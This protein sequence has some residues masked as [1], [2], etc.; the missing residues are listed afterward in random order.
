MALR[1]IYI[2]DEEE[3]TQQPTVTDPSLDEY[4]AFVRQQLKEAAEQTVVQDL[5]KSESYIRETGWTNEDSI[6]AAQR[7]FSSAALGWGDEAVIWTGAL[8]DSDE[9]NSTQELYNKRKKEYDERQRAFAERNPKAAMAADIVGGF[10][11]PALAIKAGTTLGRIGIS[12]AE[13]AIYGAG[14]AEEGER[15]SGLTTGAAFGGG[16]TAAFSLVGKAGSQLYRRRIDGDLVDADGDF[17]PL[18]I[19][20]SNPQ[21][22][23]GT[24]HTFYRDVVAP[25]FGGKG[26]IKAQEEKIIGKVEDLLESKQAFDKKLKVGLKEAEQKSKN[27]MSDALEKTRDE[28]LESKKVVREA[29]GEKGASLKS[30]LSAFQSKKSEEIA[31][32]ALKLTGDALDASNF[33]FRNEAYLRSMPSGATQDDIARVFSKETPGEIAREIDKTWGK[34]GYSMIKEKTFRFKKNELEQAIKERIEKSPFLQVDV[35]SNVPVM[36][37]FSQVVDN[38]KAFKDPNSRITGEKASEIRSQLGSL[39]YRQTDDQV[40]FALYGL[41][42]ELD[43]VIKSQ[44]TSKQLKDFQKESDKWKTTVILRDAIEKSQTTTSR[45]AFDVSDWIKAVSRNNK[46]DNRYGAGPLNQKARELEVDHKA[47]E[48]SIARRAKAVAVQKANNIEKT[49]SDHNKELTAKLNRLKIEN[50]QKKV[51]IRNNPQFAEDIARNNKQIEQ[52]TAEIASLKKELT[53]LK[54]LKSGS[55]PSWFFTMAA[56]SVL[57]GFL[58]GPV[59]AGAGLAGTAAAGQVGGRAFSS[60]TVQKAIAGQLPSQQKIQELIAADKTGRTVEALERAGGTIATRGMLT[61]Q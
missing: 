39:A 30:K 14:A 12:A 32:K 13:G 25:S 10:A 52:T 6:L 55:N 20:A 28:L 49:I 54:E 48:K 36:K 4:R 46:W 40:K 16:G 24:I 17:V 34:R 47:I 56:S 15:V 26:P 19:A 21:G 61:E 5:S 57:G 59:G 37:I 23:E 43:E 58:G 29:A 22:I 31:S 1:D 51:R 9:E 45:G 44:L 50:E 60:P 35:T 18:T 3:A 41:Q 53:K 27:A 2:R 42:N 11:T 8:L 7:F 33:N 38:V